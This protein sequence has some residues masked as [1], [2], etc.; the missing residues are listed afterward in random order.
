MVLTS[1][2]WPTAEALDL[3]EPADD[4][5]VLAVEAVD[6]LGERRQGVDAGEG[7]DRR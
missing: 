2:A 3:A 1:T 5:G 7:D 4:L 6:E